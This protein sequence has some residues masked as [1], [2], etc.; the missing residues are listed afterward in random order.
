MKDIGFF[1]QNNYVTKLTIPVAS[2]ARESGYALEDRSSFEGFDVD[3]CGIDFSRYDLM[4]PYGSVQFLRHL[5]KSQSFKNKLH[6]TPSNFDAQL[7]RKNLSDTLLNFDSQEC[8]KSQVASMLLQGPCHVRP[9]QIDKL[10][11][12]KVFDSLTWNYLLE[13][14]SFEGLCTVSPVKAI[15]QEWRCWVLNG[16]IIEISSY[17]KN[18]VLNTYPEESESLWKVASQLAEAWLPELCVVMDICKTAEGDFKI[19]E[20]NPI[21]SSGWYRANV[22]LLLTKWIKFEKTLLNL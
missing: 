7:W 17:L 15:E 8:D 12:A 6:Y 20:F 11:T 16:E 9:T 18:G 13:N 14:R 2:F 4:I 22:P 10:F 3:Q 21:Y 1:V 19:L 5:I